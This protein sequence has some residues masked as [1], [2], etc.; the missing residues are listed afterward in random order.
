MHC[1]GSSIEENRLPYRTM[2]CWRQQ[3]RFSRVSCFRLTGLVFPLRPREGM[4]P[5]YSVYVGVFNQILWTFWCSARLVKDCWDSSCFICRSR[6]HHD[7]SF[8]LMGEFGGV[9]WLAAGNEQLHQEV[10][11]RLAGKS[12]HFSLQL[13]AHPWLYNLNGASFN[14]RLWNGASA[15]RGLVAWS[16]TSF[17][18]CP[19][20]LWLCATQWETPALLTEQLTLISRAAFS[21]LLLE[22]VSR[23][24][25]GFCSWIH[26]IFHL[27]S[28]TAVHELALLIEIPPPPSAHF[29]HY[30]LCPSPPRPLSSETF[31]FAL[32]FSPRLA[33]AARLVPSKVS[34]LASSLFISSSFLF[35]RPLTVWLLSLLLVGQIQNALNQR[36]QMC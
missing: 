13:H 18:S 21:Q 19:L 11:L 4:N 26:S 35:L 32:N 9:V 33:C 23:G 34:S 16:H 8:C 2:R 28:I 29:H 31:L 27:P 30:T 15:S 22:I 20:G 24:Q 6:T 5:V 1:A 7:S 25:L 10:L 17:S 14:R 3:R 36:V 12:F